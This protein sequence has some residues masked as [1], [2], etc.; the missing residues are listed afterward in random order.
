MVNVTVT[1][2]GLLVAT[3][4]VTGTVAVWVPAV[5]LPVAGWRVS[6]AG[7]VVALSVA[8]SQPLAPGPKLIVPMPRPSNVPPP[9]L[10]TFSGEAVGSPPPAVA[11]KPTVVEDNTIAGGAG[12]DV[13]VK[14]TETAT[15]LLLAT[16]DVSSTDA[17]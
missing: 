4:D 13:T 2:C 7:A 17:S 8:V 1:V 11:E 6:V 9:P 12:A 16:G 3:P 10:E 5:R 14:V 15:G